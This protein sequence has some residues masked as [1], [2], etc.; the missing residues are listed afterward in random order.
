MFG[1][2][3]TGDG[4]AKAEEWFEKMPG[5]GTPNLQRLMD[6]F[7]EESDPRPLKIY[8]TYYGIDEFSAPGEDAQKVSRAPKNPGFDPVEDAASSSDKIQIKEAYERAKEEGLDAE[9]EALRSMKKSQQE[10][11]G[12][13]LRSNF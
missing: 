7:A 1:V 9:A 5:G 11:F 2:D 4:S 6:L 13:F 3:L 12:H 8:K 10:K